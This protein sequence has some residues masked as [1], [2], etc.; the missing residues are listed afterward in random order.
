MGAASPSRDDAAT[1]PAT[2]GCCPLCGAVFVPAGRQVW[3]SSACRNRA[4]RRRHGRPVVVVPTG[5]RRRDHTVYECADCGTRQL[6]AQRCLDCGS[7]GRAAGLGGACP[8][9]D[10][11]VTVGELGL[12]LG[13]AR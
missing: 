6:G 2:A 1:T 9:C 8:H 13:G 7:F 4:F 12:D 5:A 3:C 11:P 10:E